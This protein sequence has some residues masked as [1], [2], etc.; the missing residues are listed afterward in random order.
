[1]DHFYFDLSK[2]E[3]DVAVG[4]FLDTLL[5]ARTACDLPSNAKIFDEDVNVY[6]AHL[7]LASSLPDYQMMTRRYL[8]GDLSEIM[9]SIERESDKVARYFIYKVNADY[10]LVHLGIFHDLASRISRPLQKSERELIQ[11]GQSYYEGASYYNQQIY[12]R[13]TAVGD[14]LEK[15][16]N[17]FLDYRR[18]LERM[19]DDFFS[20]SR[21]MN[22][23]SADGFSRGKG[24][25][26]IVRDF[27]VEH[28]KNEF[29]DLYGDWL[30]TKNRD[31]I[32]RLAELAE[33]IRKIDPSFSFDSKS[34]SQSTLN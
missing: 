8:A 14:V 7:L 4:Y 17:H 28:K 26:D 6:L 2:H 18:I 3:R 15:L 19:G 5:H 25:E 20:F 27:S 12:R 29:L 16:A 31:L 30:H 1:M 22:D 33:S 13:H 34:L 11:I 23:R 9:Q 10:L 24:I 21:K 32:P